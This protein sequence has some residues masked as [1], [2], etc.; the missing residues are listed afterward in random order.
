V[1]PTGLAG[2]AETSSANSGK[3]TGTTTAM[4]Y[5]LSSASDSAY[6]AC[7]ADET[8]VPDGGEYTVRFVSKTGYSASEGILITVEAYKNKR[9]SSTYVPK[10]VLEDKDKYKADNMNFK[11][12]ENH[13]AKDVIN[14]MGEKKIVTGD[15]N[16]NYNPESDITRAEFATILVRAL[17]LEVG[18]G[19]TNFTDVAP[20]N[21]FS[22]YVETASKYELIK[23]S[24]ENMFE[25]NSKITREQA[26]LMIARAM[27][28]TG[29]E[30]SLTDSEIEESL[31]D[32][33]DASSVSDYSKASIASCLEM[34]IV[35]GKTS[36]TLEVKK[37]IT[38]AEV[39][40]IVERL[41]EKSDLM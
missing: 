5:K 27:K 2:V 35:T 41:L 28:I 20:E 34:G 39:A 10:T 38:R 30:L 24:G 37:N 15:E 4:E 29:I 13:W 36:N 31:K 21:W 11:D 40:V 6:V 33:T 12:A 3:I 7:T 25:P 22:A 17:D 16:G 26:M 19:E 23:G 8:I 14:K 18:T 32:Y 9:H 1:A